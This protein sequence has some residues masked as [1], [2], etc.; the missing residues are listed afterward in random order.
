MPKA[1]KKESKA[2]GT[3]WRRVPTVENVPFGESYEINPAGEV[4]FAKTGK[5]LKPGRPGSNSPFV[6]LAHKQADKGRRAFTVSKLV[7]L[8]F[9]PD[10]TT[11]KKKTKPAA[12]KVDKAERDHV[13]V[14]NLKAGTSV[15]ETARLA[16]CSE[17][18]VRKVKK[19]INS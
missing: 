13:I 3:E 14:I 1:N 6:V 11:E 8:A 19:Q 4:R 2:T 9:P 5:I 7:L 15:R 16:G 17:D 12:A 10:A 18:T